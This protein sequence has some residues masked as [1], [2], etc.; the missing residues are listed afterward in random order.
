MP[1]PVLV[2]E[3]GLGRVQVPDKQEVKSENFDVSVQNIKVQN[4]V[5]KQLDQT[6]VYVINYKSSEITASWYVGAGAGGGG[7][8]KKLCKT[9]YI[10]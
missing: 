1:V 6:H 9:Y 10:Y 8:A 4:I 2:Q 7:G 5:K 3:L